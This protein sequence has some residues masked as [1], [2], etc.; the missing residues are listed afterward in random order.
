MYK[1]CEVQTLFKITLFITDN[2]CQVS[3]YFNL[4]LIK[5]FNEEKKHTSKV[6]KPQ[7]EIF[8][9]NIYN[10]TRQKI[11]NRYK[12]KMQEPIPPQINSKQNSKLRE[13]NYF[14]KFE[15]KFAYNKLEINSITILE[16]EEGMNVQATSLLW[17]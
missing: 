10:N 13:N 15:Q 17:V 14:L 1:I 12:I 8:C 6:T 3:F 7:K 16:M 5:K 4:F 2:P 9:P 11:I